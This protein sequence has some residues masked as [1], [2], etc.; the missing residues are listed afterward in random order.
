[1][2]LVGLIFNP[3]RASATAG[4]RVLQFIVQAERFQ[5]SREDDRH[6]P[7]DDDAIHHHRFADGS[8]EVRDGPVPLRGCLDECSS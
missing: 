3:F 1:M 7:A 2:R 4:D 8:Y 6:P 5:V